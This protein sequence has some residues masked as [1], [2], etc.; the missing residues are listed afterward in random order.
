[1]CTRPPRGG[2]VSGLRAGR[3]AS[4]AARGQRPPR[5]TFARAQTPGAADTAGA[6]G[7][8]NSR[9]VRAFRA[10]GTGGGAPE[11]GARCAGPPARLLRAAI[12]RT[13]SV[14]SHARLC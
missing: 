2:G 11:P 14:R 8:E 10:P 3:P 5:H 1:M 12:R 4:G 7:S 13:V 9:D 6:E